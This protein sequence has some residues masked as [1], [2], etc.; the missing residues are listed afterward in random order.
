MASS[1]FSV[2]DLTA[3]IGDNGAEGEHRAGYNGIW[4]LTH[5]TQQ[6]NL[7]VPAVEDNA[8]RPPPPLRLNSDFQ[9]PP[10]SSWDRHPRSRQKKYSRPSPTPRDVPGGR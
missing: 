9:V 4:S 8:V 5:K 6:Q 3:I 10:N 7:F 1:K 2:G